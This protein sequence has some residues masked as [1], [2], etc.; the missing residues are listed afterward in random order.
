[1]E[2]PREIAPGNQISDQGPTLPIKGLSAKFF[3]GWR[4]FPFLVFLLFAGGCAG[5][6]PRGK[7]STF[8]SDP[9]DAALYVDGGYIGR[10][11]TTFHLPSRATVRIRLEL[12][13]YAPIEELLYRDAKVGPDAPE[14][15][16]WDAHYYY[17]LVPRRD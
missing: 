10:T 14:G 1:M 5:G 9:P 17:P 12:P 8:E 4:H 16:G 13:G 6:D 15:L 11:P 2:R 7:A 3:L